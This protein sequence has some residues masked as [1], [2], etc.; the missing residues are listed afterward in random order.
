MLG[1]IDV[2]VLRDVPRC[3][4][5]RFARTFIAEITSLISAVTLNSLSYF[6][7]RWVPNGR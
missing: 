1:G 3:N 7:S 5:G 2:D 6:H 4:N